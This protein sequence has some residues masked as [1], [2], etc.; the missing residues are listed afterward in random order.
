MK[1]LLLFSFLIFASVQLSAQPSNKITPIVN[2]PVPPVPAI[3]IDG[4]VG[5]L[6]AAGVGYGVSR[7]RKRKEE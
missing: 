3:P 5:L 1:K 6:V 2:G 4:G 7:L